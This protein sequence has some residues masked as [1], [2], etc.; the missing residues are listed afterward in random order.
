MAT[1]LYTVRQERPDESRADLQSPRSTAT[2]VVGFSSSPWSDSSLSLDRSDSSLSAASCESSVS[3]PSSGRKQSQSQPASVE[4]Q[5]LSDIT[6]LVQ[7]MESLQL[8]P[9]SCSS[10]SSCRSTASYTDAPLVPPPFSLIRSTPDATLAYEHYCTLFDR[11]GHLRAVYDPTAPYLRYRTPLLAWLVECCES[12]LMLD[13]LTVSS[14]V[15]LLDYYCTSVPTL[16]THSLQL[17]ALCSTLLAAKY[18]GSEAEAPSL[19]QLVQCAGNVYDADQLRAAE[20]WCLQRADWSVGVITAAH[21]VHHLCQPYC[22]QLILTHTDAPPMSHAHLTAQLERCIRFLDHVCLRSPLLCA[23]P[24]SLLAASIV[25]AARH[26][27]GLSSWHDGLRTVLEAEQD[28]TIM[29]TGQVLDWHTTLQQQQQ[30]QPHHQ[31]PEQPL[32]GM[33]L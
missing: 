10:H 5:P 16:P 6:N 17:I 29:W 19:S 9:A 3:Q 11:Q 30:P 24:P 25:C 28:E 22:L 2:T 7:C 18:C 21:F 23:L 31:Q 15:A 32:T 26:C 20:L 13:A 12:E 8:P 4:S 27:I 1:R 33:E 14:A